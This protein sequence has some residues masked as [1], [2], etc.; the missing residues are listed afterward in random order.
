[1]ADFASKVK[2]SAE[3]ADQFASNIQA[4]GASGN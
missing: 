3:N 2:S 1:M 4:Q